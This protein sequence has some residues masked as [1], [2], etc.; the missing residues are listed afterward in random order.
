MSPERWQQIEKIYHE[1]LQ[2]KPDERSAFLDEVCGSDQALRKQI[3]SL[4]THEGE[5]EDFIEMPALAIAAQSLTNRE[6]GLLEGQTF[7]SYRILSLLG[8]GGMGEVYKAR[9]FRLNRTVA[10]KFLLQNFS[11]RPDLKERFR[12]EAQAIANLNH[13]NICVIHDIGHQDGLDYL[14]MEHV[15]GETLAH[16][17]ER[18]IPSAGDVIKL[19]MEIAD[20][21]DK[22]H[23]QGVVHRDLKPNNIMLTKS[24]AK[25]LDFGLAKL[26]TN[27]SVELFT[28]PDT[29]ITAEGTILGTLQY[30]APEQVQGKEAD[31]RSDIFSLGVIL[32]EMLAGHKAFEG[33]NP[34]SVMAA[35]LEREPE[36]LQA[37]QDRKLKGLDYVIQRCIAKNPDDRWQNAHDL[38]LQVRWIAQEDADSTSQPARSMTA[39]RAV[40]L[41]GVL[42]II[43][44][45]V[46][47]VLRSP[48]ELAQAGL[49]RFPI[50]PPENGVL[51][52]PGNVSPDGRT[53]AFMADDRKG[54][55]LIWLRSLESLK[56]KLLPGTEDALSPFFWSP[57]SKQ[58]GFFTP[59]HLK[60][61]AIPEG[62]AQTLVA[63]RP[64]ASGASGGGAWG[65]DG[66]IL[67]VPGAGQP[68]FG[69]PPAGGAPSP[70]TTLDEAQ[71]EVGHIWPYFLPDGKH[72]IYTTRSR[73][74]EKIGLYAGQLGST[75][76]KRILDGN[77]L[78]AYAPPGYLLFVRRGNLIAQP[79]D[80]ARLA[81][82]GD[83]IGLASGL[84]AIGSYSVSQN[85]VLTVSSDPERPKIQLIWF[86]RKGEQIASLG[87]P[88]TFYSP[89][90]SPNGREI[91]VERLVE[92]MGQNIWLLEGERDRLFRF[93]V[94]KPDDQTPVWSRDGKFIAF[95]T[96]SPPKGWVIRR[97][98]T[99]GQ[100]EIEDLTTL[101]GESYTTDWSPDGQ[102]IVY[103]SF[104]QET[105]WDCWLLPVMGDRKPQA[106]L[107][108][109]FNE[110]Q[111]QFSPDGR[112]IAYT[113]NL[114]GR[115]EVYVRGFPTSGE[116]WQQISSN[117]GTQPRWRRDGRELF[118]IAPDQKLMAAS[119]KTSTTF[120][121]GSPVELF[122]L[123]LNMS[124]SLDSI[125]NY[126]VSADG[127]RFLVNT[128]VGPRIGGPGE[129]ASA[130]IEVIMNWNA[131]EK[132]Q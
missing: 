59:T 108:T 101:T 29:D 6:T 60:K 11:E 64:Y 42:A 3:E 46:F 83:P 132:R 98:G 10:I 118:Y 48:Q 128:I 12:R 97:K 23:R 54:N 78:A 22:V 69:I 17:L 31:A 116:K 81:L 35:I 1:A 105:R 33:K 87:P 37:H 24:G 28:L 53:V 34:A 20:A 75:D 30:M 99:D 93:T 125:R 130:L 73:N 67:F 89:A 55:R 49:I 124:Q 7:G 58:I 122:Q 115:N 117:G 61:I 84:S 51:L 66:T 120:E 45:I 119:I 94:E 44:A 21:L 109:S 107:K 90:V 62:P 14:V 91:A 86:G 121:A 104:D 63:V 16:R 96:E 47:I 114:S 18:G 56:A 43:L 92:G 26:A 68:L 95:T 100:G 8:S 127:Q 76:R 39:V 85:G 65:P 112:W 102:F 106:L 77:M 52:S 110:R 82:S 19:A 32:Y 27:R 13:P 88:D 113:S 41:I 15:E 36:S 111:V 72:F 25:L 71:E 126:D 38:L 103:E 50:H 4:L 2:R 74:P 70:V 80:A 57:D 9:D 79:F 5:A 123:R 40:L 129:P 131:A